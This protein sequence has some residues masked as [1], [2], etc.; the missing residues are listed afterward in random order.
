MNRFLHSGINSARGVLARGGSPRTVLSSANAMRKTIASLHSSTTNLKIIPFLLADIGEGMTECQLIQWFVKPGDRV[1]QFTPICE[2][3]S[4]K[5]TAEISSRYDGVITKLHHAPDSVVTVGSPLVDINVTDHVTDDAAAITPPMTANAPIVPVTQNSQPEIT[6][7][8][9]P[10]ITQK[11]QL[12]ISP[13]S[14]QNAPEIMATPAVRR[15]AKEHSIDLSKVTPTGPNGRILKMDVLAFLQNA[16]TAQTTDVDQSQKDKAVPLTQIQKSMF[17]AM[18][19]SLAIPHF[20]YSEEIILNNAIEFRASINNNLLDSNL[21]KVSFM[22]I[23]L[24][25][26][27]LALLQFPILNSCVVMNGDSPH[28]QFRSSHNLGIA[29]DTKQGFCF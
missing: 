27:S 1:E 14:L 6:Q 21:K 20:G 13:A 25:A 7:K 22:P 2:I 24:K 23:F 12:E 18:T 17:K 28:L 3:Q 9:Q 11:S 19:K 29:M 5:A 4:D 8:S 15:I 16:A 10:E 26:L